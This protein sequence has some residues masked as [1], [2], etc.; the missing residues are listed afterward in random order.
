M[1]VGSGSLVAL[2]ALCFGLAWTLPNRYT[3]VVEEKVISPLSEVARNPARLLTEPEQAQIEG[4]SFRWKLW[5]AAA[6][7]VRDHPLW[8][9]GVQGYSNLLPSYLAQTATDALRNTEHADDQ[10]LAQSL[11][12]YIQK[13]PH[14][15][16]LAWTAYW[17]ILSF[18]W[19]VG[20]IGLAFWRWVRS[21][22]KFGLGLSLLLDSA[23]HDFIGDRLFWIAVATAAG[24]N[25]YLRDRQP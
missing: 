6:A 25:S 3:G 2:I 24:A 20:F 22:E 9:V 14:N 1:R 12:T 4:F 5:Q 8:G 17:G 23:L 21:P 16:Y 7:I 19:V 11:R 10:R 18:A 13:G 15:S